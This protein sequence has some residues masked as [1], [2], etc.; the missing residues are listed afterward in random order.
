[1]AAFLERQ[2]KSLTK[3]VAIEE[4]PAAPAPLDETKRNRARNPET[5]GQSQTWAKKAAARSK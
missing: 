4:I 2:I 5:L 1:M 3:A